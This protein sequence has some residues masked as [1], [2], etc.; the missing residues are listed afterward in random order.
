MTER[1]SVDA[2]FF[3][4][5][6]LAVALRRFVFHGEGRVR[7]LPNLEPMPQFGSAGASPSRLESSVD[8]AAASFD[9]IRAGLEF[10]VSSV[11]IHWRHGTWHGARARA[12]PPDRR[13]ELGGIVERPCP[14]Q[15]R[16]KRGP[17]T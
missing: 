8:Q 1:S 5:A 9:P 7:L 12:K 6:F 13:P 15:A 10:I 16:T 2:W 3:L 4:A 11:V 14:P 17:W